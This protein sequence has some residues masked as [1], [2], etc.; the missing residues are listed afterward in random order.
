M[1]QRGETVIGN[2]S[3]IAAGQANLL[4]LADILEDADERHRAAGR[5]TYRQ[6]AHV[7]DCGTP[8]C[9]LSHWYAHLGRSW[10][11][12]DLEEIEADFALDAAEAA[13][14]FSGSGC[15]NAKT[16]KQAAA[17][18]RE[19]VARQSD[20]VGKAPGG[21]PRGLGNGIRASARTP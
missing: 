19:F 14:L 11:D 3:K 5:P 9:A 15:G 6:A 8:A 18:L 4:R 12:G 7:H 21:R 20:K 17:Y 2:S 1:T 16:A 10:L 13:E